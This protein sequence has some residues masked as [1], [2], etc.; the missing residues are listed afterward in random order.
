MDGFVEVS[1][2]EMMEVDGGGIASAIGGAIIGGAVGGFVASV[3][4]VFSSNGSTPRATGMSILTSMA[5][6][7]VGGAITGAMLPIF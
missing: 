1:Q 5:E 4:T 3:R 2:K 7:A 6:G